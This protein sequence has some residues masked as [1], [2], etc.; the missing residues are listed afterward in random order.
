[1]FNL[2]YRNELK[3][4]VT[5]ADALI[6]K[7]RLSSMLRTDP[8]AG[9]DGRYH[10]RSLYF[11]TPEGKALY[12]KIYGLP[13][14]EKFRL[15]FYNHGH[16]FIRLEKKIK[17]YYKGAKLNTRLKKEE[18]QNILNGDI[19]FLRESDQALLREF[20]LKLK[21]ERLVPKTVVDYMREAYLYPAGNVRVTLDSD[22]RASINS[23]DLFD[24][25]LPTSSALD[26]CLCILEVKFDGFLP[27]FI[28]DIIQ[29][30]KCTSRAVSKYA[31]CRVY[32]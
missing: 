28:Q 15:R 19:A 26:S 2:K 24:D 29:L 23:T 31:A 27:E 25:T 11:D 30:N 13:I 32:M 5:Q 3:H 16:E 17:H 8:N 12:E 14:K 4:V 1:M 22:I 18:V 9:T 10:I 21:T 20:Y 7:S 6:I